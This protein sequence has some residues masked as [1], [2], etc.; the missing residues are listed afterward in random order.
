MPSSVVAGIAQIRT[1]TCCPYLL[2]VSRIHS[3]IVIQPQPSFN[4]SIQIPDSG[5]QENWN[6][7]DKRCC[8]K[9][10]DGPE[11]TPPKGTNLPLKV[12]CQPGTSYI[13]TLNIVHDYRNYSC[14]TENK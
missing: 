1:T 9:T 13:G 8:Y 3:F 4:H 6:P 12:R 14:Y 10:D 5:S 11:Q 2:S 7:N